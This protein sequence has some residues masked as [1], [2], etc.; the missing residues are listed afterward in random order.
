MCIQG[1]IELQYSLRNRALTL[2]FGVS[3][4]DFESDLIFGA[5]AFYD[6]RS[7]YSA[8]KRIGRYAAMKLKRTDVHQVMFV[9]N[10]FII[11]FLCSSVRHMH[12][13]IYY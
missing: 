12:Y 13:F 5:S 8:L 11:Q 2:G 4:S 7:G 6:Q 9:Y 3:N 1:A 10:L